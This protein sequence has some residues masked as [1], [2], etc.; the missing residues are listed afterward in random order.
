ME[1]F[2]QGIFSAPLAAAVATVQVGK[3]RCPPTLCSVSQDNYEVNENEEC[4]L[5]LKA[6]RSILFSYHF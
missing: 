6:C 1:V 4:I 3:Q 5:Y 2:Q